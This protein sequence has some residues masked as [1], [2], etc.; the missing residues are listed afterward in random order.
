MTSL[1]YCHQA[2]VLLDEL[3]ETIRELVKLHA[4][5]ARTVGLQTGG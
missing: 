5:I 2:K 3:S 1:T 4:G